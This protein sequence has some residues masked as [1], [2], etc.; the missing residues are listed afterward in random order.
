MNFFVAV[1]VY[2]Y[3]KQKT[4]ERSEQE[5]MLLVTKS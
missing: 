3:E 2:N 5:Q 1:I 4:I